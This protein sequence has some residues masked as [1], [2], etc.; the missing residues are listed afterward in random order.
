MLPLIPHTLRLCV[1]R[2]HHH[3]SVVTCQSRRE[4]RLKS[5]EGGTQGMC[6]GSPH[7]TQL[8]LVCSIPKAGSPPMGL[9]HMVRGGGS[10]EET[11]SQHHALLS[12]IHYHAPTQREAPSSVESGYST[13]QVRMLPT[14]NMAHHHYGPTPSRGSRIHHRLCPTLQ[15]QPPPQGTLLPLQVPGPILNAPTLR[16]PVLSQ[17]LD[18]L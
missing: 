17:P 10:G 12:H 18:G 14:H 4:S 11:A 9:H 2:D 3:T 15:T 5:L 13:A 16:L 1:S 7:G 8:S 6:P